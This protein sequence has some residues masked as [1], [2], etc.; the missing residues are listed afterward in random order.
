MG[1]MG[2]NTAPYPFS[3]VVAMHYE[4]EFLLV[5]FFINIGI[6]KHESF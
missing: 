3:L 6:Q 5:E 4:Q 2:G 1:V